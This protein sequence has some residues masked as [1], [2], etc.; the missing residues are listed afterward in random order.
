MEDEIIKSQSDEINRLNKK[1]ESLEEQIILD[2][3][4][5]EMDKEIVESQHKSDRNIWIYMLVVVVLMSLF[6]IGFNDY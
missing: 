6:G 5:Q 3:G 1:I 2:R 4:M